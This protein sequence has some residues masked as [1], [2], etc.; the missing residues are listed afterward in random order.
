M[1][2]LAYTDNPTVSEGI[3]RQAA[4][5]GSPGRPLLVASG[6]VDGIHPAPLDG[7]SRGQRICSVELW[8]SHAFRA[9]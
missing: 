1:F 3:S 8:N 2:W 5:R 6:R 7:A 9:K 4:T